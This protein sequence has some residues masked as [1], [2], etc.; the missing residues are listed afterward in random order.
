MIYVHG[1]CEGDVSV[2]NG[3]GL[4]CFALGEA[5][6]RALLFSRGQICW[7]SGLRRSTGIVSRYRNSIATTLTMRVWDRYNVN[8]FC[9]IPVL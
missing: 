2:Q 6:D 8:V 4:H 7:S 1:V 3:S 9:A 5:K